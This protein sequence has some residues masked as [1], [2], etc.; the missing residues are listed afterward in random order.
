MAGLGKKEEEEEAK[1]MCEAVVL[2]VGVIDYLRQWGVTEYVE[3][4][5]KTIARDI[6]ARERNHA[7]VPVEPFSRRFE[8]FLS[9]SMFRPIMITMSDPFQMCIRAVGCRGLEPRRSFHLGQHIHP[10]IGKVKR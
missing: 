1:Q 9:N 7:V 8:D 4:V 5:Q 2:R 3:H 6:R 10:L